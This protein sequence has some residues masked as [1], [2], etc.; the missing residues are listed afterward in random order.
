MMT[1]F[2]VCTYYNNNNDTLPPPDGHDLSGFFPLYIC[3]SC[4][5]RTDREVKQQYPNQKKQRLRILY[6]KNRLN[7]IPPPVTVQPVP[8]ISSTSSTVTGILPST[9]SSA[10]STTSTSSSTPLP[11]PSFPPLFPDTTT[12]TPIPLPQPPHRWEY[13]ELKS[14][15]QPNNNK[16][17][18]NQVSIG[19]PIV[20]DISISI[21]RKNTLSGTPNRPNPNQSGTHIISKITSHIPTR[22]STGGHVIHET[23]HPPAGYYRIPHSKVR[24]LFEL[25]LKVMRCGN[26]GCGSTG[27]TAL[28]TSEVKGVLYQHCYCSTCGFPGKTLST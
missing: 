10:A 18:E 9:S 8:V 7:A 24:R 21:K 17:R 22:T 27:M 15:L 20:H 14:K 11:L 16:W 6:I 1:F 2:N 12:T 25:E 3:N 23:E 26:Y 5:S 28:E 4:R 13:S 19:Y